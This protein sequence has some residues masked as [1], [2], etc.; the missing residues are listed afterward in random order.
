MQTFQDDRFLISPND[1]VAIDQQR[2]YFTNDHGSHSAWGRFFEDY[3]QLS[4]S[5]IV[6]CDQGQYSVAA[7]GIAYANGI[8][9]SADARQIYVAATVGKSL[10]VYERDLDNGQLTSGQALYLNTGV[11][12]IELDDQSNLWIGCH[13][14]LLTFVK[15]SKNSDRLSPSQVIRVRR[16]PSGGLQAEEIL[17]HDGQQLSGSS[18]AAVTGRTLLVGSVFDDG[19]LR[20]QLPED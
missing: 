20:C 13:P 18:V 2:F 7:E 4:R 3:L 5:N 16:D 6:Y 17:L 14:K 1:V 9:R 11:D 10:L 8:N 15:H 19:I 12:N